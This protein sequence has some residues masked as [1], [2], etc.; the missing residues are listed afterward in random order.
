DTGETRSRRRSRGELLNGLEVS[1]FDPVKA[2]EGNECPCAF[3]TKPGPWASTTWLLTMSIGMSRMAVSLSR[4][5][6]GQGMASGNTFSRSTML[7][8]GAAPNALAITLLT[9]AVVTPQRS[10]FCGSTRN[11]KCDCPL[12]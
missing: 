4:S 11:S 9:S 1:A 6:L 7:D 8:C 5:L 12:I 3:G 2:G 10:H